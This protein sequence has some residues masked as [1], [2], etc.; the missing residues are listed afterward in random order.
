MQLSKSEAADYARD[1]Y[2]IRRGLFTRDEAALAEAVGRADRALK[3]AG[4]MKDAAG[5]ESKIWLDMQVRE[6]IY[7][8][9]A[10]DD[11]ILGPTEQLLESDVYV[12]HYKMMMK[13]PRVGGAWEWHQD[14]GYWY[15]DTCLYPRL[16]SCMIGVNRATKENGCL[17]V[18]RGSH[19]LGRLNHGGVGQQAGAEAERV[20]A[21]EQRLELVYVELEPGDALFFHSNLLHRSAPNLSDYP[22]WALICC[23]NSMENIPYRGGHGAPVKAERWAA[24]AILTIGKKQLAALQAT[25]V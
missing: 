14:Y 6:D 20:Q 11:R 10:H 15:G 1:G 3:Q 13:E 25:A 22:R 12:W 24:D 17:Q 21:A 9:F 23:Y 8:A 7:N 16:L 5:R 19:H 2:V 18:L 4:A